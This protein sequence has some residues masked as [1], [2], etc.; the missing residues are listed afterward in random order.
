MPVPP[1]RTSDNARHVGL[2]ARPWPALA[3]VFAPVLIVL[4]VLFWLLT[5][6]AGGGPAGELPGE[7][8]TPQVFGLYAVWFAGSGDQNRQDID[9]FLDCLVNGST[10]NTYW[11]GEARVEFRGSWALPPPAKRLDWDE[12]AH[13]WLTPNVGVARGLPAPT[14]DE[15]PVY[16]VLGGQPDRLR[17]LCIVRRTRARTER[18]GPKRLPD[19]G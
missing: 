6:T 7:P 2:R 15:T 5:P 3:L 4:F 11:Q 14:A 1:V 16:L 10:L 13:A 12:L 19:V 8:E 9:L 18:D 17:A